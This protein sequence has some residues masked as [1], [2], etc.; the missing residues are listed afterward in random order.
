M[1]TIQSLP[2]LSL[3]CLDKAQELRSQCHAHGQ[4]CLQQLLCLSLAGREHT[5][6]GIKLQLLINP[7]GDS[8]DSLF[9]W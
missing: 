7:Q 9:P 3:S 2:A 6:G 5:H 8:L 1:V 4:R